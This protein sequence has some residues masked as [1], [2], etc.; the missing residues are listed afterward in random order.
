MQ[1]CE[2]SVFALV[3]Q[4]RW[5]SFEDP[6]RAFRK[7]THA[8]RRKRLHTTTVETLLFS[9]SGSEASMLYNLISGPMVYALF[10]C[11]PKDAVYAIAFF[12][13]ATSGSGDRPREG[14]HG[15]GVFLFPGQGTG[16]LGGNFGPEKK[17]FSPPQIPRKHHPSPSPPRPHPLGRPPTWDFQ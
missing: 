17:I 1:S 3:T 9:V 5:Y 14:R 7:D 8:A 6:R 11:F 4:P 2:K 15:G 13:S 16:Y 12:C 10:P